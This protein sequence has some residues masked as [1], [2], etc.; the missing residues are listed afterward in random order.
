[1]VKAVVKQV[2]IKTDMS[3]SINSMNDL[4]KVVCVKNQVF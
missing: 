3:N 4:N 1:M 2:F